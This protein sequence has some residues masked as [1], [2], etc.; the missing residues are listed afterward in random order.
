MG[1][2][3]TAQVG[4]KIRNDDRGILMTRGDAKNGVLHSSQ[5]RGNVLPR[6]SKK[7][8]NSSMEGENTSDEKQ[9]SFSDDE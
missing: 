9:C 3:E 7:L 5:K 1:E 4:G 2:E 6:Q 8:V